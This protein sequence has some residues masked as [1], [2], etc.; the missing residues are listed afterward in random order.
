MAH[1]IFAAEA[2]KRNLAVSVLSAGII[3]FGGAL[4]VRE[5]RILCDRYN[6]PMPKFIST[7]ITQLDLLSATRVFVMQHSHVDPL[8]AMGVSPDR[9]VLL[10]DFDPEARG[11]EIEDPMGQDAPAF[12][13]CYMRLRDCIT[14]YLESTDDFC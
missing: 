6:T 2:T 5:A 4:A 3:D 14:Q 9:I 11:P 1:A 7:C 13:R 12:E 8:L 10:G